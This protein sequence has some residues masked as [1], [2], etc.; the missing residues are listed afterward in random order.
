MQGVALFEVHGD[1]HVIYFD[2]NAVGLSE[3]NVEESQFTILNEV[4]NELRSI[5]DKY[6]PL[7][8]SDV[9][10][11]YDDWPVGRGIILTRLYMRDGEVKLVLLASYGRSLITKLSSRL[12]KLGWKPIF[13]FDIRKVARSRYPQR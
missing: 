4:E 6:G 9:G 8:T 2:L 5:I 13:I 3:I 10:F 11:E 7:T 12:S 1:R